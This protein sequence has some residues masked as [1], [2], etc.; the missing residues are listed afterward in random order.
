MRKYLIVLFALF[1]IFIPKDTF[2][3]SVTLTQPLGLSATYD[4]DYPYNSNTYINESTA[5]RSSMFGSN[6]FVIPTF[7]GDNDAIY[8]G[9]TYVV[10]GSV[11]T[12][13]VAF[14]WSNFNQY[15]P[16][17]S[18][19]TITFQLL[20]DK[21]LFDRV[22]T[23]STM[24]VND[25]AT[26]SCSSRVVNVY[27]TEV[28]CTVPKVVSG[29]NTYFYTYFSNWNS[30]SALSQEFAVSSTA[31]F[32]CNTSTED[33]ISNANQN[34]QD[35][36]NNAN[37]NAQEIIE[38]A[39]KNQQ[40]TNEKLDQID[41]SITDPSLPDVDNSLSGI[42][43]VDKDISDLVLLPI[44]VLK[45]YADFT[46]K[47]CTPYT[48]NFGIF[49]DPYT[50]TLPCINLENYLGSELISLIDSLCVFFFIYEFVMLVI[51]AFDSIT[52]LRDTYEGLYQPKHA[53]YHPRHGGDS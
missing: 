6:V 38:N 33:V 21:A 47:S 3:E 26:Y 37:Q 43:I 25:N 32:Q 20:S 39:N 35:I 13:F 8:R 49:G 16:N 7:R 34:K 18:S 50:L 12:K 28:T 23:R 42:T 22:T 48:I 24:I 1:V 17:N 40:E 5:P 27:D 2:A 44:N 29:K 19:M 45:K 9:A 46:N 31:N 14:T 10:G 52:E 51:N 41:D 15:C 11:Y 4:K 30:T 53:D 36:I